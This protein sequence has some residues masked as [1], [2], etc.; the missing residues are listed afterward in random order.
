MRTIVSC[1]VVFLAIAMQS[2]VVPLIAF[3]GVKPDLVLIIVISSGLLAGKEQGLVIGFFSGLLQDLLSG[4][5]FGLNTLPKLI[6]G[7]GFG[8]AERTVFK[9]HIVLPIMAV[10]LGSIMNG[11]FIIGLLL[12]FGYRIEVV[13]AFF[14]NVI[15]AALYNVLFSLPIHRFVY[16]INR[17]R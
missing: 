3:Q 6:I 16:Y 5:I 13:P 17:K 15:P 7:Y 4:S 2:A 10:A 8:L 12:L 9:E 1:G 14:Y 11:L